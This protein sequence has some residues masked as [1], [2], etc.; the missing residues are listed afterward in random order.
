MTSWTTDSLRF[1]AWALKEGVFLVLSG[2]FRKWVGCQSRDSNWILPR[3]SL[4][5]TE[6]L[7]VWPRTWWWGPSLSDLS[8][9]KGAKLRKCI[10]YVHF[11]KSGNTFYFLPN[12]VCQS[13]GWAASACKCKFLRR[14]HFFVAKEGI[15]VYSIKWECAD[16]KSNILHNNTIKSVLVIPEPPKCSTYSAN[17][18]HGEP[19][20]GI[21]HHLSHF[22][23]REIETSC[24][25]KEWWLTFR[26]GALRS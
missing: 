20:P 4:S 1:V 6:I 15:C 9:M 8:K 21:E 7:A 26:G 19:W 16:K 3:V 25:E 12:P 13:W 22:P 10:R 23:S 5:R 18:P 11:Q 17:G 14:S 24:R 2:S